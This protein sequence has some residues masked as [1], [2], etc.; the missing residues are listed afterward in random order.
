MSP[1]T[2][3]THLADRHPGG[4]A[5]RRERGQLRP[6]MRGSAV[7]RRRVPA[8]T[9]P[10]HLSLS[11]RTAPSLSRARRAS[12]ART[13]AAAAATW[14]WHSELGGAGDKVREWSRELGLAWASRTQLHWNRQ[15][16]ALR[17]R[18]HDEEVS[19]GSMF[20]FGKWLWWCLKGWRESKLG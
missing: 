11:T 10:F 5:G 6:R 3:K 2:K 13:A 9:R 14:D 4:G 19:R 15:L 20:D 7:R 1:L 12:S 18:R 17:R 16:S 8:A